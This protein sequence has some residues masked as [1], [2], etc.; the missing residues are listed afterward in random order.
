MLPSQ[1]LY[2]LSLSHSLCPIHQPQIP[3]ILMFLQCL[4]SRLFLA[5]FPNFV[6]K[7]DLLSGCCL[8]VCVC[9]PINLLLSKPLVM[10]LAMS[11]MAPEPISA[12]FQMKQSVCSYG[13]RCCRCSAKTGHN[14]ALLL[15]LGNGSVDTCVRQ[16]TVGRTFLWV[17][18][19]I[20]Y[21]Y[22]ATTA[23]KNCWRR[24]F[25]CGSCYIRETCA[26]SSSQD[27]LWSDS[28]QTSVSTYGAMKDA[29][30]G[31]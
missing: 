1:L 22:K 17:C 4:S 6:K 12:V 23:T 21:I 13:D 15:L 11:I 8:L 19:C 28:I 26:I 24:L 2:L 18:L 7:W 31:L 20:I 25:L 27:L 9:R 5:Y 16:W 10:K 30:S 3:R 29:F 14:V